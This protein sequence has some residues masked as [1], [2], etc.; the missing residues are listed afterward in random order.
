MGPEPTIEKLGEPDLRVD[1]FQLWIHGYQFPACTDYWDGNWLRVT[2]HCGALGA[3]VWATGAILM[4]TDLR[5]WAEQC[6]ALRT[7]GAHVAELA[8]LEPE[9]KV[10]VKAR[11][12]LGHF[13]VTV[14]ITPDHMTQGH[15]FEFDID[16]TYLPAIAEKC[17]TI[18]RAYP[19][20]GEAEN[21]G[22]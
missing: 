20:R 6:D 2:A 10:L 14:Q 9:L 16:Q 4:N 21:R 12:Q 19:V 15:T 11:D 13:V 8:P 7:G 18:V 22:V 3:S 5:H 1:G 17:R